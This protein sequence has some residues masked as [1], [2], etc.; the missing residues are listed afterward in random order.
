MTPFK[1]YKH[2]REYESYFTYMIFTI[3]FNEYQ[4]ISLYSKV[5]FIPTKFTMYLHI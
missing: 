5:F 2:Y 1:S 4:K 3:M